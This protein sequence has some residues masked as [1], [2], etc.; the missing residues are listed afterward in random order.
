MVAA[1]PVG[2]QSELSGRRSSELISNLTAD[3]AS[4]VFISRA[5]S[6]PYLQEK[7]QSCRESAVVENGFGKRAAF[8]GAKVALRMLQIPR[9]FSWQ[10]NG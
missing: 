8:R 7:V 3:G 4:K 10:Y 9:G 2:I 6:K 1:A 5:I